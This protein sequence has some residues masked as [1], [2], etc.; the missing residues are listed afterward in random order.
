MDLGPYHDFLIA[1][2]GASASFIGLLFVAL[3]LVIT[4]KGES[5][6]LE[7]SD[8]RLAESAFTALANVFFVCL[9]ALMPDTNI[10]IGAI[11]MALIGVRSSWLLFKRAKDIQKEGGGYPKREVFWIIASLVIYLVQ[12]IYAVRLLMHPLNA[13][14]LNMMTTII[15]TLFAAGLAR[16]WEL[17]G[18]KAGQKK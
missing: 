10:G 8:R 14:D 13:A 9:V 6:E 7:F 1:C 11:V 2:V 17:T 3:S 5:V 4:R 16:S 15:I 18:I 12:G